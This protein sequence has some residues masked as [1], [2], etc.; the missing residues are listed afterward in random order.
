MN[1][2]QVADLFVEQGILQASQAD[3]VL[4]EVTESGKSVQEVMVDAGDGKILSSTY[5][6]P[7]AG[8]AP[9]PGVLPVTDV[10]AASEDAAI[11][12]V[13]D[14]EE[15]AW[16]KSDAKAFAARFQE[17]GT[18]T[19]VFGAVSRTRAELEKRQ[20][21]FFTSHFK[22]SRL[23]LKVRKVR[24]L[25][26]DVSTRSPSSRTSSPRPAWWLSPAISAC[27]SRN[28]PTCA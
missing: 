6:A 5:E 18:F 25:R 20:V 7:A 19:D 24:F 26:P 15:D 12:K 16:N 21:E 3:D 11:R 9:P 4:R 13:V 22:G 23:A 1:A 17:D 8:A 14:A 2:K 10:A 28:R 27:R